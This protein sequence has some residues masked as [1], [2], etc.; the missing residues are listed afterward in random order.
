MIAMCN[1]RFPVYIGERLRF[2]SWSAV[3]ANE[4]QSLGSR[5]ARLN[6]DGRYARRLGKLMGLGRWRRINLGMQCLIMLLL[7]LCIS[8][9]LL[10]LFPKL[11]ACTVAVSFWCAGTW[12]RSRPVPLSDLYAAANMNRPRPTRVC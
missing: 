3:A 4:S 5:R 2:R 1:G 12:S 7:M 8:L 11:L 6:N 10:R 9:R